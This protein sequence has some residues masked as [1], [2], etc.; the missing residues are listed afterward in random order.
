MLTDLNHLQHT[1]TIGSMVEIGFDQAAKNIV[2]VIG[3]V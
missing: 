2:R 3:V 1:T